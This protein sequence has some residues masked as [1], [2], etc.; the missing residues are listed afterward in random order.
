MSRWSSYP[1]QQ[2]LVED[3]QRFVENDEEQKVFG[4]NSE[5]NINPDSLLSMLGT[6]VKKGVIDQGLQDDLIDFMLAAA[7]QDDVVLEALGG[8]KPRDPRTFSDQTTYELNDLIAAAGLAPDAEDELEKTLNQWARLNTVEFSSDA[9]PGLGPSDL[10]PRGETEPEIST[11]EDDPAE[12]P[13]L[14]QMLDPGEEEGVEDRA[15]EI[16]P[17]D[18]SDSTTP[19][20]DEGEE[21]SVADKDIT[22]LSSFLVNNPEYAPMETYA[23]A[24]IDAIDPEALRPFALNL[25]E[26]AQRGGGIDFDPERAVPVNFWDIFAW[27]DNANDY[28]HHEEHA[29]VREVGSTQKKNLFVL[30]SLVTQ[31]ANRHNPADLPVRAPSLSLSE[32][33][34]KKWQLIAG[35]TKKVI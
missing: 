24:W 9:I 19:G 13:P 2:R 14:W 1:S 23:K 28:L 34:F 31:A 35:I 6:L 25:A 3:W 17:E 33:L 8:R 21:S 16:P 12:L 26:L 11:P 32:A 4:I 29:H 27:D 7:D 30:A 15:A 22:D 10:P 5:P 20:E 18:A